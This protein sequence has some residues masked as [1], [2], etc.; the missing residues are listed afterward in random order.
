M[1]ELCAPYPPKPPERARGASEN[2]THA[3]IFV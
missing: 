3:L 1:A 2:Y